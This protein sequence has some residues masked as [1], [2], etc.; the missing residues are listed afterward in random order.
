MPIYS[1]VRF[2]CVEVNAAGGQQVHEVT[3]TQVPGVSCSLQMPLVSN[4]EW[5]YV[6]SALD[7]PLV[8]SS[9]TR[10]HD[11]N[12]TGRVF[13]MR[14]GSHSRVYPTTLAA[15]VVHRP[16]QNVIDAGAP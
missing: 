12:R 15:Q 5:H 11:S 9:S 1:V 13:R 2:E 4:L 16:D 8:R 7:L 3:A 14:R 6:I 10:F